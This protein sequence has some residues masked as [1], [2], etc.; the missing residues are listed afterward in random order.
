MEVEGVKPGAGN[1][2]GSKPGSVRPDEILNAWTAED[3]GMWTNSRTVET[4]FGRCATPEVLNM[5]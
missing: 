5:Q 4:A 2:A 3:P 1:F